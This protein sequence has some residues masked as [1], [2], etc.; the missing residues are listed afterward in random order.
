M[1]PVSPIKRRAGTAAPHVATKDGRHRGELYPRVRFVACNLGRP[2]DRVVVFYNQP[3]HGGA[4]DQGRRRCG[5][6]D[7]GVL[8]HLCRRGRTPAAPPY[9]FDNFIAGFGEAA[10]PDAGIA[11]MLRRHQP[12]TGT[13]PV[14]NHSTPV[15]IPW[16]PP[17][18]Q[19]FTYQA[20]AVAPRPSRP[21]PPP[22]MA[23]EY[24][25]KSGH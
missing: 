16:T 21:S 20:R 2:V 24:G 9:N 18:T 17:Y 23:T 7:A 12:K 11:G 19:R 3:R 15:A 13:W 4:A 6:I 22:G 1:M 5:Q 8:P 14:A 25:T 10:A